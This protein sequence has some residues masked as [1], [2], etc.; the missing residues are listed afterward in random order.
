[1]QVSQLIRESNT[2]ISELLA[3]YF[4]VYS[5]MVGYTVKVTAST[6]LIIVDCQNDLRTA[7][8]LSTQVVLLP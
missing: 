6:T 7:V 2:L 5:S 8:S 4:L 1:M 3:L